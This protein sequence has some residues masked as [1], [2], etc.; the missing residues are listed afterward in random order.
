[1]L[2]LNRMFKLKTSVLCIGCTIY[3]FTYLYGHDQSMKINWNNFVAWFL[4]LMGYHFEHFIHCHCVLCPGEHWVKGHCEHC[5]QYHCEHCVQCHRWT[6]GKGS[7]WTLCTVSLWTLCTVSQCR[8]CT[9]LLCT[10]H[11]QCH[12]ELFF[13]FFWNTQR[14]AF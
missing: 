11:L 9:G 5:V 12:G 10:L 2:W 1:M 3:W 7:L 6:L 14:V 4:F 8:L 13:F